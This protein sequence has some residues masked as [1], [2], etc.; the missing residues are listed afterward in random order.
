[1]IYVNTLTKI[2][3]N[4]SLIDNVTFS[5]PT[6]SVFGLLGPN[7]AGKSTLIKAILGFIRPTSGNVEVKTR[8]V[9]YL[10]ENPY[11]YD[12]LTLREL[13]LFSIGSSKTKSYEKRIEASAE[14]VGMAE[15]LD[16]RL[17]TFSKGMVQRSGIAAALIHQPELVI[18]DEPMSGLDPLG[19]RMVFDS[20]CELRR[21]GKT[22]L[23]CS[24][25]INDVERL[26]DEVVIMHK[27]RS[28][29]SLLCED[30]LSKP[31]QAAFSAL[32]QI[33]DEAVRENA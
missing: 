28:V 24:H 3:K 13:L 19:R 31:S 30:F 23:F 6:G 20:V 18:F 29:R 17:R 26:C 22:V 10:P 11:Y 8:S 33:F 32:E 12:Y 4:K 25:I 15:H 27:G 1:M 16:E 2:I 9:G 7:G 14:I 5:V 21:K